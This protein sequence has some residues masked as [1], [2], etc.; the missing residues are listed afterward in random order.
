MTSGSSSRFCGQA[1]YGCI[2]KKPYHVLGLNQLCTDGK[3]L[4]ERTHSVDR[5]DHIRFPL[6][7][8]T[9]I[10]LMNLTDENGT[11]FGIVAV[12]VY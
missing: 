2:H 3:M 11:E 7:T 12:E 1:S 5:L 6:C 8:P 10:V 9:T 4:C